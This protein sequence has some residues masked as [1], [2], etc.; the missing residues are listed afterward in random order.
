MCKKGENGLC[1]S[2]ACFVVEG[3]TQGRAA[4]PKGTLEH[5]YS[6]CPF[7]SCYSHLMAPKHFH[8]TAQFL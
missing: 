6:K 2:T 8:I 7:V 1:F 4:P 5:N 3:L